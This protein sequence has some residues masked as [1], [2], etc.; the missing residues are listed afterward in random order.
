MRTSHLFL[1]FMLGATACRTRVSSSVEGRNSVAAADRDP[2]LLVARGREHAET[3]D[4]LRAEQYFAAALG[5]GADDRKV[6]PLLLRVCVASSHYRYAIDHV[7]VALARDPTN[8]RLRFVSGALHS[9]IG[10]HAAAR[11]RLERTARELN[12]D[13]EIQFSVGTFFRDDLVDTVGAD[14][15]FREYLRL[16][17]SGVHAE[18]A[19][20]SSMERLR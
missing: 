14:R 9:L 19:R 15:Y 13:P 1:A 18:E 20:A 4:L 3:G 8:S 12:A 10:A 6:L 7:E 2:E 16:A 17:P 11:E 5:A